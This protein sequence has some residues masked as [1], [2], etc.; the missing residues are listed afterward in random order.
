MPVYHAGS[1]VSEIR[2][3][4]ARVARVICQAKQIFPADNLWF[5][6]LPETRGR[7]VSDAGK[8][9]FEFMFLSPEILTGN[10]ASGWTD[11]GHYCHLIC[12]WSPDLVHWSL[13]KFSAAPTPIVSLPDGTYEYWLRAEN[14]L[15][16]AVKTGVLACSNTNN[17][18]R[19]NG[20]TSVVIAGV[21][22]SLPNYPYDMSVGGNR[23]PVAGRSDSCWMGWNHRDW[24][25]SG[26]VANI[27]PGHLLHVLFP[28]FLRGFSGLSGARIIWHRDGFQPAIRR[29]V[30]RFGRHSDL[31]PG[32]RTPGD[33]QRSALLLNP[34]VSSCRFFSICCPFFSIPKSLTFGPMALKRAMSFSGIPGPFAVNSRPGSG[35]LTSQKQRASLLR[36]SDIGL[37]GI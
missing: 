13:G 7:I 5:D 20:F 4:G 18:S 25:D 37:S 15:D 6:G 24:I 32:F 21:V 14:P 8:K 33:L 12:E 22:Q 23:G 29:S 3:A 35:S 26:I 17:D 2:H 19:N 10:P 27:H 31:P 11:A 34:E 30:R 1:R 16:A 28:E 36:L 9:R